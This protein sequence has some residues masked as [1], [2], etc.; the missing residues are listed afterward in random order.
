MLKLV[1]SNNKSEDA[2]ISKCCYWLEIIK[3]EI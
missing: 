1:S 3:V 2:L